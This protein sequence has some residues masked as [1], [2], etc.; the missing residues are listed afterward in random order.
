MI[1]ESCRETLPKKKIIPRKM[2]I[3]GF[4][5]EKRTLITLRLLFYLQLGLV[6]TEIDQRVFVHSKKI[7]NSFVQSAV[8]A[9]RQDDEKPITSVLAGTRE[10]LANSS[11]GCQIVDRS[12]PLRRTISMTKRRKLLSNW[13]SLR[14]LITWKIHY[15]KLNPPNHIM[16]T[17]FHR[18][19]CSS[20]CITPNVE[21]VPHFSPDSLT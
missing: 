7:L 9:S 5:L 1:S 17:N 13:S 18:V 8:D 21:I 12:R 11:F 3:S 19:L 20:I 14:R 10:L 4:V 6:C 15:I 16:N 2:L